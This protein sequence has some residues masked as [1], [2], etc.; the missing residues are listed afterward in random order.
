M[1]NKLIIK[2][3]SMEQCKWC[4]R[5]IK[6][7]SKARHSYKGKSTLG[8]IGTFFFGAYFCCERCRNA[9]EKANGKK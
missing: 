4:G 5:N 1:L 8:K 6:N 9:W 2:F 3:N 7:I